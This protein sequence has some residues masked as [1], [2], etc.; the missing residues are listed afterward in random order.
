M[1]TVTYQA[2]EKYAEKGACPAG[3]YAARTMIAQSGKSPARFSGADPEHAAVLLQEYCGGLPELGESV[4]S[5]LEES[6]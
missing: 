4:T 1:P 6:T 5:Q 2:L 3:E